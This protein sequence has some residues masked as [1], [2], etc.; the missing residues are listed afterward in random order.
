DSLF[1]TLEQLH[2]DLPWGSVLDAGTGKHSL[3]WI[4]GLPTRQWTGITGDP[5]RQDRMK[6]DFT[7]RIRPED[8]ILA[9]NWTDP[10]LLAG[11]TFDVVL[12]DYLLGALD[13]FAPYF[14]SRLFARLRPHVGERLYLVGLAP[15]PDRASTPGGKMILEIARLRDSCILLAGHRC[16]REY[17]LSWVKR[18]LE[19]SGFVVENSESM[20]IR[21]GARFI[22]GQLDV[23]VRKLKYF[24]DQL[25]ASAMRMHIESVRA[26]ALVLDELK[27]GG[28][29]FGEDY[30]VSARPV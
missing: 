23:C 12:A 15:Y 2:G 3:G 20:A 13:G 29:R 8:R 14:Q 28:I 27:T 6:R 1:T 16:Y 19:A 17:P 18:S 21:Y 30:V 11:E 24:S 26:R 22:N 9:G 4:C 10:G 25:M 7:G 5:H